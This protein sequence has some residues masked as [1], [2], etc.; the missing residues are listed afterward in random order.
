MLFSKHQLHL[1][2]FLPVLSTVTIR[3]LTV[4]SKL[5]CYKIKN[6]TFFI[7]WKNETINSTSARNIKFDNIHRSVAFRHICRGPG[8][9]ARNSTCATLVSIVPLITSELYCIVTFSLL[10]SVLIILSMPLNYK[11]SIFWL[12]YMTIKIYIIRHSHSS[13]LKNLTYTSGFMYH[14]CKW[15]MY[16]ALTTTY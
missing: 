9:K 2:K 11:K 7:F 4:H 14:L 1:D 3:H 12:S 8:V 15:W 5:K 10:L 13:R 16:S 6:W